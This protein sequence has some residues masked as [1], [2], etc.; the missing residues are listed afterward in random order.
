MKNITKSRKNE[1][2]SKLWLYEEHDV[3][4]ERAYMKKQRIAKDKLSRLRM[5]KMISQM[6]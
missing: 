1:V 6:R 5:I 3:L 2:D 4:A